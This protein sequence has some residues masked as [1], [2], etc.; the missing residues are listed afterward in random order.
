MPNR[1]IPFPQ[2]EAQR[3][4]IHKPSTFYFRQALRE[5]EEITDAVG[6]GMQ[7]VRELEHTQEWIRDLGLVP[8]TRFILG[9]E[10]ADK[11]GFLERRIERKTKGEVIHA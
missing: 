11:V 9:T 7:A 5:T 8:P 3:L 10:L 4:P 6:I 1:A 2:A